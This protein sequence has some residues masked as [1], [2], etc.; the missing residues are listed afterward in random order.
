MS[1]SFQVAPAPAG[2]RQDR[3]MDSC[4]SSSDTPRLPGVLIVDDE[5]PVRSLLEVALR[6]HGFAAWT[7]ANGEQ[8][9]HL[10]EPHRSE[11]DLVL[12]DVRMPGLDGPQTLAALRRFNPDILCCFMSGDSGT[13]SV[14]ALLELGAARVFKKPFS[15]SEIIGVLGQLI[16]TAKSSKS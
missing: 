14:E 6:K 8:A 13:Y 15:L 7:A 4:K 1:K 2:L 11:I 12:L 9:L 5:S 3:P 16:R 10:Y